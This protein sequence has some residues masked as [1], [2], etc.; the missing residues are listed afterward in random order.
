MV[1]GR[2]SLVVGRWSLVRLLPAER[3]EMPAEAANQRARERVEGADERTVV[4]RALPAAMQPRLHR[5]PLG[6]DADVAK[7]AQ[8]PPELAQAELED[9]RRV[10]VLEADL[11]QL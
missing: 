5:E 3:G 2:S 9:D 10:L 4:N 1:F 8:Q 7:R 6:H 11:H